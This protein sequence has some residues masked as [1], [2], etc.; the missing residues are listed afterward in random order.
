MSNY[1]KVTDEVVK[2]LVAICGDEYVTTSEPLRHSYMA[3]GIMGM[4][5]VVPEVVIRPANPE[6][7]S[8]VLVVANDNL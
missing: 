4:E 6:Q 5:A 2:K 3:R 1:N 7:V 8:K